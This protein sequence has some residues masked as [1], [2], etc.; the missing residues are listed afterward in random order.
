MSSVREASRG[1]SGGFETVLLMT[2]NLPNRSR[3]SDSTRRAVRSSAHDTG[4][5]VS[6]FVTADA[7]KGV[8]P[9]V[10]LEKADLLS[11]FDSNRDLIYATAS[12]AYARGQVS[13][14]L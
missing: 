13:A 11:A 10:L 8:Q 9:D 12:K 3:S 4:L 1:H 7:L 5:Q 2:L 6:F 14:L